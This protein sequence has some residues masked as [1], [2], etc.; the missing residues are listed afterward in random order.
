MPVPI[1]RR[2]EYE[3]VDRIIHERHRE[4]VEEYDAHHIGVSKKYKDG[5]RLR[6]TSVTFY[7]M[8]K[9]ENHSGKPIPPYLD[10]D[11][12]DGSRRRIATDVCEIK[13]EPRSLSIRGGN[14]VFGA[15]NEEG[16]VGLVFRQGDRDF[17]ITNAHVV[18]DPGVLPGPVTVRLP[19]SEVLIEGI[20][21]RM[22]DLN[23]PVLH[24]D[25]AL[26]EMPL[27]VVAPGRFRGTELVLSGY[28]DI[29]MNDPR[30]FYFVSKEFVHEARWA[31]WIATP[32]PIA[33]DGHP[34]T[35]AGFHTLRVVVGQARPGN[36]GAVV[37]CVSHGGLT[38]VGLLFGGAL[39]INEVWVFPIRK[40]LKG[41]GIDV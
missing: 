39:A 25:A 15:D 41:M 36:S 38:A 8:K 20:V 3:T 23:G 7:V 16:T 2:P 21:R 34:K 22:D 28:S 27:N 14:A 4:L 30:K 35:C 33:I 10:I 6:Q 24:S 17:M 37:F 1:V 19:N 13:E 5:K 40:C 11:Y 18:T 26:V 12:K 9:G 31:A 32:T 29:I